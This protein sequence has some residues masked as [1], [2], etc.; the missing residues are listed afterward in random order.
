MRCALFIPVF[1]V[2]TVILGFLSSIC[3]L[4]DRSG[5]L[6]HA[7]ARKWSRFIFWGVGIRPK[8]IGVEN[9]PKD[10]PIIF[11]AN[12]QSTMDIPAMFGYLP[13]EFR[14]MAKR[15]LFMV[16]FLGWHLYLSGNIPINRKNPR[17]ARKG[18]FKASVLIKRGISLLIFAEGTRT[19]DGSLRRFKRGGFTLARKLKVPIVPIAI[20]GTF[21]LMPAGAWLAKPGHIELVILPPI[22]PSENVDG[23]ILQVRKQLLSTGLQ[24]AAQ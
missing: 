5:R 2:A 10:T 7:L 3:A 9:I 23:T 22:P 12:H 13:T 20:K 11:A 15:S 17:Q 6:S 18:V 24:E 16:P 4:F 14:I 1:V 21:E 8:V 19:R